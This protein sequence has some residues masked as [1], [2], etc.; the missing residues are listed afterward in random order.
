MNAPTPF[1]PG[2]FLFSRRFD[3]LFLPIREEDP[4]SPLRLAIY[5][6]L[7]YNA[8]GL[9]GPAQERGATRRH[10]SPIHAA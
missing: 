10:V 9:A 8:Q 1:I 3:G 4:Y 2:T 7:K 5:R 6:T